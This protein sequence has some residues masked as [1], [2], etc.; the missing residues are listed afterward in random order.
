[1]TALFGGLGPSELNFAAALAFAS[2][3]FDWLAHGRPHAISLLG[4]TTLVAIDAILDLPPGFQYR[5]L[6]AE[7]VP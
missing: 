7:N 4:A 2:S 3:T 5:I 6:S 1:M